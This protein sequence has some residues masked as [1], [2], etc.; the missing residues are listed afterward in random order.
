MWTERVLLILLGDVDIDVIYF[1]VSV[2]DG[3]IEAFG[4]TKGSVI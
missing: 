2:F 1:F 3:E 4:V